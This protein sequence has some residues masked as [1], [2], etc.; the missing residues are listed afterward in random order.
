MTTRANDSDHFIQDFIPRVSRTFALAIKFLPVNIRH[1]V[2]CAYLLCRLADTL[3][4]SP[5][6]EPEEKASRLLR[7]KKLLLDAIDGE[8]LITKDT[9]LLYANVDETEGH[10]HRL[11]TQSAHLFD[12]LGK[13]PTEHKKIIFRWCGEMAGGMAEFCLM[14][15]GDATNPVALPDCA[16]W[17]RYCYYVAGTVG[18][19]L[20]E[21]FILSSPGGES[22]ISELRRLCGSFGLGLQKINVIKDAPTDRQ[23]GI[24]YLPQDLIHKYHLEPNQLADPA[25]AA[26][27]SNLVVELA[28]NAQTHLDDAMA[29]VA[30][31]PVRPRGI[32]MFLTVP[33][34]LAMETLNLIRANPFQALAGPPVKINRT[35]VSRIVAATAMRVSSNKALQDYYRIL[36]V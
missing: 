26:E 13:L 20:T 36:F 21:L 29:Y 25:R 35:D 10:D 27:I 28:A 18:Y 17:D 4:D 31:F 9:P 3:E 11:L 14:K 12:I 32:R 33:V 1:S 24:I 5:L 6:I 2:Y 16:A 15:K 8:S 34:F 30:L 22:E 23:R 19:M 7:L